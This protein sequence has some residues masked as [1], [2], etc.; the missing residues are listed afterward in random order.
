M[1]TIIVVYIHSYRES[2]M[3][4]WSYRNSYIT[5]R[6]IKYLPCL[7]VPTHIYHDS[8]IAP[9]HIARK[10]SNEDHITFIRLPQKLYMLT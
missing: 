8:H 1:N 7:L 2:F 4:I 10:K 3:I 5:T 6:N 9:G